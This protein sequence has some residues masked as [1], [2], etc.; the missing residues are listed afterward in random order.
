MP[1][2][3]GIDCG[4]ISNFEFTIILNCIFL[5]ESVFIELILLSFRQKICLCKIL[6]R[7]SEKSL[8]H[9]LYKIIK[10]VFKTRLL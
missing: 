6:N 8:C 4:F 7:F 9:F 5:D 2:Y 10:Y 3:N 1:V